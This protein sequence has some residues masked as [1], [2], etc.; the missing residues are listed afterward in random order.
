[1]R[2]EEEMQEAIQTGFVMEA[3][4]DAKITVERMLDYVDLKLEWYTPSVDAFDFM[5]FIRLCIGDEPENLNSIAHYFF[6]DCLFGS[7]SVKPYFQVRGIDF[8]EIKNNVLILSTREF[9][10]SI[11]VTYFILYMAAKGKKPGFGKVN[12]GVYVSDK[13]EGNVKTTMR[14]IEALYKGSEYLRSVFEWVHL[15]DSKCEFIRKPSTKTEIAQYNKHM[16]S[17]GKIDEVPGRM[18]RKFAIQGIGSSGGRG[19]R[20]DL[21]RPEFAIYDDMI[22]NEKDAF[23]KAYLDAIESTIESDVGSSLSGNGHFQILIGTAYHT[24]DPVYRRAEEG[25]WLPVVFP[26]AEVAPHGD[27]YDEDGK[28]I[29]KAITK[30]EFVS[31]WEDRHSFENQR[32]VYALAEK[33]RDNGNPQ[34]IKSI[35]QEYYVR[36]TSSHE[37]LIQDSHIQWIDVEHIWKNAKDYNWYLSTDPTTTGNSTSNNSGAMLFAVD[38]NE[39]FYLMDIRLRKL[40]REDQYQGYLNMKNRAIR[41]G[42]KW[43]DIA[44]EIDGQQSLHIVSLEGFAEKQGDY[45]TF[46]KQAMPGKKKCTWIGIRSKFVGSKLDRLK[47]AAPKFHAKKVFFNKRLKRFNPDMDELLGEIRM[48]THDEIKAPSDDGLDTI[49]ILLSGL[50]EIEYPHEPIEENI[51][52]NNEENYKERDPY[53]WTDYSEPVSNGYF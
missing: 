33:A 20:D 29:K 41:H 25:T 23:S 45:V 42:A 17:G 2:T 52:Y 47:L 13:M 36:V 50:A 21:D 5:N 38:W 31:V 24:K 39:N 37:R 53:D 48:T 7:E 16:A 34:K 10:K 49:S 28:L 43:V 9:G 32:K 18:K 4:R 35:D 27:I 11:I 8:D 19:S 30:E 1:V 26:K 51:G 14:T 6:V 46:A 40:E 15:T 22:G 3:F 44:M 12:F